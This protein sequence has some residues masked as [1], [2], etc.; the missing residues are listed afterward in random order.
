[1]GA[2]I[3]SGGVEVTEADKALHRQAEKELKEVSDDLF[4]ISGQS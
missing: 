3:S 2:C 1:M 4:G